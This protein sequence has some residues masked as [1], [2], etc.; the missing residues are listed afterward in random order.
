MRKR[1]VDVH[2]DVRTACRHRLVDDR[3]QALIDLAKDVRLRRLETLLTSL[4]LGVRGALLV[5]KRLD[6]RLKGGV[7]LLSVERIDRGLKLLPF[8]AKLIGE[9]LL[10]RLQGSR[11]ALQLRAR[12]RAGGALAVDL[13]ETLAGTA[14]MLAAVSAKRMF[15]RIRIG[16]LH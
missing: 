10:T 11:L 6:A 14:I 3:V 16:F 13:A 1:C 2:R 4:E 8:G 9:R 7:R 15:L 12:G 5:L